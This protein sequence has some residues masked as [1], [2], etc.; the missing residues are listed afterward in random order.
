M[1]IEC[2]F[3][4]L[5]ASLPP[6]TIGCFCWWSGAWAYLRGTTIQFFII[7][8]LVMLLFNILLC[9]NILSSSAA[10]R[11]LSRA[12]HPYVQSPAVVEFRNVIVN[13]WDSLKPRPILRPRLNHPAGPV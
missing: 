3:P 5:V 13:P 10:T 1:I 9:F 11:A 2:Q 6:L 12:P 7:S 4:F 8:F